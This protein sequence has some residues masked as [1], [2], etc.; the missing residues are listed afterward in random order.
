[1]AKTKSLLDLPVELLQLVLKCCSTPSFLQLIRTC[2]TLLTIAKTCRE[3]LRYQLFK[4]PGLLETE[5]GVPLQGLSTA[6]LYQELMSRAA[7]HL[8]G[9]NFHSDTT[10]YA[11]EEGM[12]DTK[13]S[14]FFPTPPEEPQ[15]FA[16]PSLALVPRGSASVYLYLMGHP[17]LRPEE[18]MLSA[19]KLEYLSDIPGDIEILRVVNS[20]SYPNIISVLQRYRPPANP[21]DSPSMHPFV[22]DTMMPYYSARVRL[23]HYTIDSPKGRWRPTRILS[24]ADT[25]GPGSAHRGRLLDNICYARRPE[26]DGTSPPISSRFQVGIPFYGYH[27]RD[28]ANGVCNWYY[29][30]VGFTR[31]PPNGRVGAYILR[32][33]AQ[34]RSDRCTHILNLDRG[35]RIERWVTVAKLWGFIPNESNLTG[36]IASS[37]G[38]TR[39]AIANWKTLYVWPLEPYHVLMRNREG[40]YPPSMY[41]PGDPGACA[42]ASTIPLSSGEEDYEKTEDGWK[43][44]VE[45]K[46][47]ILNLDAVCF[48]LK[49]TNGENE[50]TL[51]TDKG[52]MVWQLGSNRS[53]LRVKGV[54]KAEEDVAAD[55]LSK[56]HLSYVN[57]VGD[58][59]ETEDEDEDEDMEDDDDDGEEMDLDA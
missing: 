56:R 48:G 36:L 14:S 40:Y 26:Y 47:I 5:D 55:E 25:S 2:S 32:S 21:A 12:I 31:L 37:P 11:M 30:S 54:I 17:S 24:S 38:G 7:S 23:V 58:E 34:C 57:V 42:R 22:E 18:T 1:M 51:L 43:D 46:P 35:R 10:L 6:H 19:G 45:L 53:A 3:V 49:F 15:Y 28:F 33:T 44:I 4:L 52:L 50:L 29:A 13:A 39:L 20:R 9:A 8:Y 59:T 27:I 41:Y 16:H